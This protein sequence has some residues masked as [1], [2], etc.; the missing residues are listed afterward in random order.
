MKMR[1]SKILVPM[2]I[3]ALL[4]TS[5]DARA[6]PCEGKSKG[7]ERK[8][9]TID[10][11]LDELDLAA[12]QERQIDRQRRRQRRILKELALKLQARME[13]LGEEMKRYAVD[14]EKVDALVRRIA[15]LKGEILLVR[16]EGMLAIKEI[17]TPRQYRKLTR[18]L[19]KW[20]F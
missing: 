13:A 15:R 17:L 14:H 9:E 6:Y 7:W 10:D 2:L 4:L 3:A 20:R 5:V 12:K 16:I 19:E 11:V 1:R 8:E 18:K